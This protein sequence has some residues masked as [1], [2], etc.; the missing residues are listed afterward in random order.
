MVRSG[1]LSSN[2][3]NA[4]AIG[5][6]L[7]IGAGFSRNWGG[8]LGLFIFPVILGLVLLPVVIRLFAA[9]NTM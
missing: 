9:L 4:D 5:H 1:L 7:L 3:P 8:P 2:N 6:N